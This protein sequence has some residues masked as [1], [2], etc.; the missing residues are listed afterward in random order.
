MHNQFTMNF[1]QWRIQGRF[2]GCCR[3]PPPLP[4]VVSWAILTLLVCPARLICGILELIQECN[5][6]S[7]WESEDSPYPVSPDS[8]IKVY[9][10]SLCHVMSC[11][12][13][14]QNPDK[15]SRW[16]ST[17]GRRLYRKWAFPKI[18]ALRAGL[19]SHATRSL[20]FQNP[21]FLNPGSAPVMVNG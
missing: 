5:S 17:C 10:T 19:T 21:P 9:S 12:C 4:N 14:Q 20:F 7:G 3:I 18:F 1:Y 16:E 15:S 8:L 11:Q 13:M 6:E 2:F